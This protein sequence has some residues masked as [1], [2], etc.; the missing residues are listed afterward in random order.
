MRRTDWNRAIEL[1]RREDY[2]CVLCRGDA[3]R[4]S[5]ER[6]VKPL[7]TLLDSGESLREFAA[8]YLLVFGMIRAISTAIYT[9]IGKIERG[10][11]NNT[12]AV[13]T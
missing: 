7:L 5:R 8:A 1:L 10:K 12:S 11:H 6:G 9:V 2:T 3:I 4:W 13:K